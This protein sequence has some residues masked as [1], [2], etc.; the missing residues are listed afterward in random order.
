MHI[1]VAMVIGKSWQLVEPQKQAR[2]QDEGTKRCNFD[3]A[4][5]CSLLLP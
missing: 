3:P 4:T 2:A 5:A 1:V